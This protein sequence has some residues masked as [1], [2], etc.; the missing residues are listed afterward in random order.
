MKIV[1]KSPHIFFLQNHV[2]I[3]HSTERLCHLCP[4]KTKTKISFDIHMFKIHREPVPDN[5]TV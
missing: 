4:F 2:A 3:E 5:M 1:V